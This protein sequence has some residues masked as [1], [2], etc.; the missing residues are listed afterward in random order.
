MSQVCKNKDLCEYH[1][2]SSKNKCLF[3]RTK[4]IRKILNGSINVVPK[5]VRQLIK[6]GH[7]PEC[8]CCGYE[9]Y[10]TFDHVIPTSR[11]GSNS[12]ENGQILCRDCNSI[13]A[14]KLISIS[15][16]KRIKQ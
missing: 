12:N 8:A 1:F 16:L 6:N 11:G 3:D 14:D 13:K 5:R 7:K 9:I 2:C 4:L 15:Q 10:L